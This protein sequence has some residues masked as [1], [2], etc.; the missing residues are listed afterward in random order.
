[1]VQVEVG[2]EDVDALG[3]ITGQGD[4]EVPDA[5]PRVDHDQTIVR[6]ADLH[7]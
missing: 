6:E 1:V 5:R 7:A 4:A 2:Q 3:M